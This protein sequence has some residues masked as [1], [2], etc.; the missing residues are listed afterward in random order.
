M[1]KILV[2][3]FNGT[4]A[5]YTHYFSKGLVKGN[6]EVK[7]LGKKKSSFLDVFEDL[8]EYLGFNLGFKLLDYVLNWFWLLFNY[9]KFDT[10]VIQWLQLLK[11][12]GVEIKLLNY[13]QSRVKLIYIVHNLYPHNT[14][15]NKLVKRYNQ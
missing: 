1:K 8:N 2:V 7:I 13:L 3:D 11:Y 10:I 6:D 14:K 9:Q 4:S 5:L 12:T 15:N